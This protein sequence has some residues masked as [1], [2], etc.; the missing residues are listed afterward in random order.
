MNAAGAN[1]DERESMV[2]KAVER[3]LSTCVTC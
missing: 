3:T 2:K 1:A